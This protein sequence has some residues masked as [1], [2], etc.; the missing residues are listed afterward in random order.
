MDAT[1]IV[2]ARTLAVVVALYGALI[3]SFAWRAMRARL[4][5]RWSAAS[6]AI[7]LAVAAYLLWDAAAIFPAPFSVW[8]LIAFLGGAVFTLTYTL[9]RYQELIDEFRES[10]GHRMNAI[11]ADTV[12]EQRLARLRDLRE[13]FQWSHEERRKMPHLL[14]GIF[15]VLYVAVG[16]F[17]VRG[18]W[19]TLYGGE[20]TGGPS[21][22]LQEAA[23][24]PWLVAGHYISQ[25]ALWL[26]FA[27]LVPVEL[28]RLRYP[29][30]SY[31]FKQVILSRLR[32]KEAALFGA[33]VYITATLPLAIL[34]LN[35]E[36]SSW[37]VTIP[38]VMAVFG[39]TVFA[40]AAS[41][42]VGKRYGRRKWWHNDNKSLVGTSAGALVAFVVAWPF[43]G[44]IMAIVAA[45]VF[46]IV[47]VGAPKPIPVTDNILNPVALALAFDVGQRFLAPV[48][49]FY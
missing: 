17:I 8:T 49:P 46:V 44:T 23:T 3:A 25:F 28:L 37:A 47:D 40:D 1:S 22:H 35:R 39:V 38:A 20:A 16:H 33:H 43:T 4:E 18:A 19:I 10:F 27:V 24:G 12:P 15:L 13:R 7:V 5:D 21:L 6:A 14:M 34:W 41:A 11:L 2:A 32:E 42:I 26:I 9:G 30:L 36:P 48:I 45:A 31:P 29:E